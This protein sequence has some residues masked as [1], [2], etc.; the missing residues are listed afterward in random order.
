M[1]R[2]LTILL[3]I[4]FCVPQVL[5]EDSDGW[6][7][8]DNVGN[9]WDGQKIIKNKDYET[10]IKALEERKNRKEKKKHERLI[11]K[12]KG[13]S[14]HDN[15]DVNKDELTS[16]DPLQEAEECQVISIPVDFISD[17]KIVERGFYRILGEKTD[18]GA[19]I[20]LYQAHKRVAKLNA[21][22]TNDDFGEEYIQFAKLIPHNNYRMKIIFGCLDFN[23][24]AYIDIVE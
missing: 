13:K 17:G 15:M 6:A 3:L 23:A 2:V 8:F 16:Q 18:K 7:K 4:I 22:L 9:D 24:Y 21:H 1:K 20:E 10:T 19:F 12:F 11:R 14:L 5:A